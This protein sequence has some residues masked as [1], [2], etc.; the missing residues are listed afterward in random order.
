VPPVTATEVFVHDGAVSTGETPHRNVCDVVNAGPPAVP[1]VARPADPVN[2]VKATE[3]PA[4]TTLPSDAADGDGGAVTVGVIDAITRCPSES[5]AA[6]LIG[7][8][9]TPVNDALGVNVTTPVEVFNEY[10]PSTVVTVDVPV[11][12]DASVVKPAQIPIVDANNGYDVPPTE[13]VVSLASGEIA[14]AVFHAPVDGSATATG[15]GTTVGVIVDDAVRLS[16][17]VAVYCNGVPT[18]VNVPVQFRPG[19]VVEDGSLLD[20]HG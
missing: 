6:Y 3:L 18:P 1:G 12:D 9:T 5:A 14:C 2:V 13:L 15:T 17:S 7:A 10:D 11:H 16:E 19:Y 20:L 8:V 4:T